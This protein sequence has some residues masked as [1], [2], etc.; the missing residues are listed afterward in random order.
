[1]RPAAFDSERDNN[2]ANHSKTIKE[3]GRYLW[4]KKRFDLKLRLI[5]AILFLALAKVINIYVPYLLKLT[6]D[7]FTDS[8]KLIAL[9]VGLILAYGLARLSVSVFGELRDLI[10]IK[11][12]QHAQRTISLL[13]F[14]HLHNLSLDFHLSRQTGGLSRVIERGTRGVNF[15]LRFLTFNIIPTFLELGLV[16]AVLVYNFDYSYAVVIVVTIGLYIALTLSVTEWRL[17]FRK[18]MNA[19]ESKANTSAIDSLINFETVKYFGNEEH[20][21]QRF[22]QSLAGYEKA[23]IR[24]QYS[25]SLLNVMQ[26]LVICSGLVVIML[27]AGKGVVNETMTV[28]DFVL[29]NTYMIQLYLPLNFLGFV[30]R[31]VKN[32]LVDMEKMFELN[33]VHATIK[34]APDASSGSSRNSKVEFKKVSFGYSADR[35]ILKDVSFSVPDGKNVAIVGPSGAG[36]STLSR[37]LFR[38]YDVQSGSV[39]IGDQDIRGLKQKNLR[40]QIGVVPQDTVLFNDSIGYNIAYGSPG[41]TQKEIEE[42]AKLAQIHDFISRL[43][44]GYK[45]QVGERGLKLS[46]GEKQ[47]V[48]IAR[49]LLKKPKVL[50]FD[51]ATSALD[52]HTEQEILKSFKEIS[53]N[54]TTLTIAH[55]LSTVVDADQIIVLEEGQVTETGT[56]HELLELGGAYHSMWESQSKDS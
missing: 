24:S 36:K 14:K 15:V 21:Y 3:L 12:V 43:T 54:Y 55:R 29:V 2:E 26:T 4:P 25:L 7:D 34:D 48:A 32:S 35:I 6:I 56:H 33:R 53:K 44:D 20:E 41:A 13:T 50:L 5:L 9:P 23:A 47:R 8:E 39:T 27:K 46:G 19:K 16:T 31:E 45:T 42:V 51:E 40:A 38:F 22:D 30:Y 18:T 10:F 37:L 52:T 49:A 17:K 1:M 11:V 28:G